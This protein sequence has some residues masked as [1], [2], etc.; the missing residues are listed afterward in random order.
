MALIQSKRPLLC[1]VL[2]VFA[3]GHAQASIDAFPEDE[4]APASAWEIGD[5]LYVPSVLAAAEA[6]IE[7]D[8]ETRAPSREIPA[9]G[10]LMPSPFLSHI[11]AAAR[12]TDIEPALIH[13]VIAVESSFNPAARSRYGAL[14]LMQLMP[15]TAKRYGVTNRLDPAQNIQ[16]GARYLRDLMAMFD[17][18]LQ[19]VLAAYNAGEEAVIRYGRRIP[20]FRATV[21]FVPRVMGYYW[22]FRSDWPEAR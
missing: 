21:A 9:G 7:E 19:L 1:A 6:A 5:A 16:G 15:G 12:E 4:Q 2:I 3:S 13:A 17:N 8:A 20:P 14:G 11:L 18:D 22:K 10:S